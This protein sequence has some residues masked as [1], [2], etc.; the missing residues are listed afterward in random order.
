MCIEVLA[1]GSNITGSVPQSSDRGAT[2]GTSAFVRKVAVYLKS[3][4][5]NL[6]LVVKFFLVCLLNICMYMYACI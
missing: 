4:L 6:G 5:L 2:E 3:P 1:F